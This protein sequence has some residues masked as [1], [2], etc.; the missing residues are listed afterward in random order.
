MRITERRLS[1]KTLWIFCEGEKTEKNYFRKLK[2]DERVPGLIIK[3]ISPKTCDPLEIIKYAYT[4]AKSKGFQKGDTLYC[5]FD[6][7]DNSDQKLQQA[8]KF[9][10]ANNLNII[11]SNPCFE[12]WILS[13]FEYYANSCEY[14]ELK[15]K[16]ELYIKPYKKNDSEIYNKTKDKLPE[17]IRNSKKILKKHKE[18]GIPQI[19]RNSNPSTKVFELIEKIREIKET[20]TK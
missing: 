1:T 12:Y 15:S 4:Y 11:F 14:P 13:H 3:I 17:A 5:V 18:N 19:S 9:A 20:K 7:D 2:I 6:R 8:E 10:K 16:I